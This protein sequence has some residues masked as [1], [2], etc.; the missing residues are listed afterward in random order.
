MEVKDGCLVVGEIF[1]EGVGCVGGFFVN[2]VFVG[3]YG[4]VEYVVID[5][6]VDVRRLYSIWEDEVV[7]IC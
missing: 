7:M 4:Y 2:V 3:V 1:R 6:L 5:D